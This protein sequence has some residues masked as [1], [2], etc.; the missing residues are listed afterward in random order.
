[1]PEK[2][3]ILKSFSIVDLFKRANNEYAIL[4]NICMFK[5]KYNVAIYSLADIIY[6]DIQIES[7]YSELNTVHTPKKDDYVYA[8]VTRMKGLKDLIHESNYSLNDF[9][10]IFIKQ[11]HPFILSRISNELSWKYVEATIK[12]LN[13]KFDE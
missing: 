6:R 8:I 9:K 3:M 7:L 12:K 1:M 10:E 2:D 11:G 13:I 4:F 5:K